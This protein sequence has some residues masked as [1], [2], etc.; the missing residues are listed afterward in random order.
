MPQMSPLLWINLFILCLIIIMMMMILLNFNYLLNPI[1]KKMLL[2]KMK[3]NLKIN[4]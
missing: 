3:K 2:K 4:W 1:Y